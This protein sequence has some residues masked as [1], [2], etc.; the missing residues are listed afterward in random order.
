[1]TLPANTWTPPGIGE[2][3]YLASCVIQLGVSAV[4]TP[5]DTPN[6]YTGS[7]GVM[8]DAGDMDL[9]AVMG[10]VGPAGQLL[11]G[12]RLATNFGY[13]PINDPDNLPTLT[14]SVNDIGLYW[15]ID[16]LNDLGFVTT[17]WCYI[18]WGSYY[19]QIMMG[20][21]GEPGPVP[22][23]EPDV[24]LVPPTQSGQMNVS[25]STLSPSW[26]YL[27]PSP[28]G[29]PGPVGPL[30]KFPD[31]NEVSPAA[32]S[33]SVLAFTGSYAANDFPLWVP[34]NVDQFSPQ[35]F[36]MPEGAFNAYDGVSQ[37]APIGSF[38]LPPQPFPWTPIVWGHLA[39][40]GLTV[41]SDP[42]MIG[43]QVLLDNQA[44]GQQIG[45]GIGNTLGEVNIM[46]HYST[47][48]TPTTNITPTNGTA[49]VPASP[50]G[51]TAT[52]ATTGGT[53]AAAEYFY[54]VTAVI[55]TAATNTTPSTS[56]ESPP[57]TEVSTTVTGS[58]SSVALNWV[59][60]PTAAYNIY[61]GTATDAENELL[62]TATGTSFTDTGAAGTSATPPLPTTIY[63]NLWNDG[64]LGIYSFVPT[65]TPLTFQSVL[66]S[67]NT[68]LGG[69]EATIT[70]VVSQLESWTASV[71]AQLQSALNSV[72]S[73]IS[74]DWNE[75]VGAT[76]ADVTQGLQSFEAL[77]NSMI[78]ALGLTGVVNEIDSIVSQL[79][80]WAE[81]ITSDIQN[82]IDALANQLGLI[83][84][85]HTTSE[86]ASQL[87]TLQP[88]L[89]N[90]AD[91]LGA[92]SISSIA[93]LLG[94][95]TG[96]VT[97][98]VQNGLNSVATML[99]LTT[100]NPTVAEVESYLTSV[101]SALT[102]LATALGT[103]V[104]NT[105][106]GV[107]SALVPWITE[108][109]TDPIQ[110]AMNAVSSALGSAVT[111]TV[112][113][114]LTVLTPLIGNLISG[115]TTDAQLFITVM[116]LLQQEAT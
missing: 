80:A 83:G 18:W 10:E 5:P 95:F 73:L 111:T 49:V 35:T 63:V 85:G 71:S 7:L 68:D 32:T 69:T 50:S 79:E 41:G 15:L 67:L 109:V 99:G 100:A 90:L 24:I 84:T 59:G 26:E 94:S 78:S 46:P 43:V 62:G 25:G 27:C 14:N 66:D 113:D 51:L 88:E 76:I 8:G 112:N 48:S 92:N 106:S 107:M 42:L 75:A 102:A 60:V 58:T 72:A 87:S 3:V 56:V 21:V 103:D 22:G 19:R 89:Q 86:V 115:Y 116:P 105:V 17:T 11:F 34:L 57:S 52:G 44:S 6:Q 4:T 29:A 9:D 20:V 28:I 16:E 54:K 13:A 104:N 30:I 98:D 33:P 45:R 31:V 1:M 70:S 2:I 36:S 93:T 53:L 23:V 108:N 114:L 77:V 96:T 38:A 110:T 64:Q 40:G 101:Q 91:L 97:T 65:A 47:P 74:T 12:L 55:T 61:R 81:A 39:A 82:A 37:Q